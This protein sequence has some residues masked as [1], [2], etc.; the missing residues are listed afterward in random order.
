MGSMIIAPYIYKILP[1][2]CC[3]IRL[4]LWQSILL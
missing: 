2:Q 3:G 1:V 4:L